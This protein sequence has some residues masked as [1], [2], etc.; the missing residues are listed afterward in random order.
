MH[1][2]VQPKGVESQPKGVESQP[3][4]VESLSKGLESQP[5][6]IES[7]PTKG[8]EAQP[9]CMEGFRIG[10]EEEVFSSVPHLVQHYTVNKLNI[11]GAE[12]MLLLR[13]VYSD[14]L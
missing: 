11:E 10:R 7:Q 4:G 5:K 13:P 6:G 2:K 8:M 9:K 12:H 14:T 3:K 1:L